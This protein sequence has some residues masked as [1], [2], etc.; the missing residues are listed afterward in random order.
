M[1]KAHSF[2]RIGVSGQPFGAP[3]SP[4]DPER[5]GLINWGRGR[6]SGGLGAPLPSLAC[7]PGAKGAPNITVSEAALPQLYP[8]APRIG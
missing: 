5:M 2:C 7:T 3:D 8:A 4:N 6:V 1:F